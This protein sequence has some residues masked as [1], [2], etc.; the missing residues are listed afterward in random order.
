MEELRTKAS[1]TFVVYGEPV[2]QGRPRFARR[3]SFVQ[4]YDP[5]KSREY[6]DTVYSVAVQNKPARPMDGPLSVRIDAYFTLP[7]SAKRAEK[8]LAESESLFHI[9]KGDADN[10]AKAVLDSL[11]GIIFKD[12]SQV[13][14]LIV[15][16]KYTMSFPRMEI[17]IHPID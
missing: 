6:K 11:N 4:A 3:G 2:A 10:I 16:Q 15:T 9:K 13:S 14:R 8:I 1:I 17:A 12:D 5:K 7:K